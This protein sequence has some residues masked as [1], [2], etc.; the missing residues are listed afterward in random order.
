MEFLQQWGEAILTMLVIFILIFLPYGK[1]FKE[2][3][4]NTQDMFL[5]GYNKA[6]KEIKKGKDPT[7]LFNQ[8]QGADDAWDRGWVQACSDYR[9]KKV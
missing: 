8:C 2:T 1:I 7:V 5:E 4:Y 9:S 6:E 3:N